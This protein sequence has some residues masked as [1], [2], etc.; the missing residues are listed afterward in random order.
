MDNKELKS[1]KKNLTR[2]Q[3]TLVGAMKVLTQFPQRIERVQLVISVASDNQKTAGTRAMY[4]A[5][6]LSLMTGCFGGLW[7]QGVFFDC[8]APSPLSRHHFVPIYPM[9]RVPPEA[10]ATSPT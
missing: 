6:G 1:T 2:T 3:R 10:I 9:P 4:S 7:A 5:S 8:G